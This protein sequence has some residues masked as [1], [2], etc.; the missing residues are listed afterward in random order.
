[1][2]KVFIV[3]LLLIFSFL[4]F[5]FISVHK[6][7]IKKGTKIDFI[8]VVKTD[9]KLYAYCNHQLIKSYTISLGKNPLG[10]KVFEGDKKTPEGIYYIKDKN[11]NSIAYKNL[12]ISYPN[13]TDV[14]NAKKMGKPPGGAIKI[15]GIYNGLGLIG[16]LH[17]FM[18]WTN[19]CIA[20]TNDEMEELYNHVLM[21][22]KIE[23]VP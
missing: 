16:R 22:A 2:K 15:H 8:R 23:I 3:L 7:M 10:A 11:P 12:G 6:N 14:S 19:G 17:R 4:V 9:R 18:D 5:G 1:M 20:V 21:G 13:K